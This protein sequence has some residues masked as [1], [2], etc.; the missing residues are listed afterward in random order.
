VGEQGVGTP[1]QL[2]QVEERQTVGGGRVGEVPPDA[3]ERPRAVLGLEILEV[4]DTLGRDG[5]VQLERGEPPAQ[6][7]GLVAELI[8]RFAPARR[9][10]I[11]PR[12]DDVGPD[13]DVDHCLLLSLRTLAGCFPRQRPA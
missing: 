13:H 5:R 4:A 3:L 1:P 8:Q 6:P 10:D 11:A 9:A 7:G 2:V 12:S